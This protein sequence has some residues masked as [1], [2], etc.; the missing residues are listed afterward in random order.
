MGL[1]KRTRHT[2]DFKLTVVK[3]VLAGEKVMVVARKNSISHILLYRWINEYKTNGKFGKST[4]YKKEPVN[5]IDAVKEIQH[6]SKKLEE[7]DLE[8]AILR[9]MLKKRIC[10]QR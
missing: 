8:I 7:Q 10:Y 6:L 4:K 3:E 2:D 9:D 5:L 1:I